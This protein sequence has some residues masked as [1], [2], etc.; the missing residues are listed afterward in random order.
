[1]TRDTVLL[2]GA[3]G[4]VGSSILRRL[5]IDGYRV[6]AVV[7]KTSNAAATKRIAQDVG[8]ADH[9]S[10]AAVPDFGSPDAFDNAVQGVKYIIHTASPVPFK[11]ASEDGGDWEQTLITPAVRG[12]L[13]LLASA[14]KAGSVH[15]VVITSSLAALFPISFLLGQT[16]DPIAA[17]TRQPD[18]DPPYPNHV[19][20]YMASKT[21][22]LNAAEEWMRASMRSFDVIHIHPGYI[23]GRDLSATTSAA[24]ET[25]SNSLILS[26]A[27]GRVAPEL[28]GLHAV[29]TDVEDVARVHVTA[30]EDRVPG[31]RSFVVSSSGHDCA[32]WED[33]PA[34]VAKHYPQ[35]VEAGT[36]PANAAQ[37]ATLPADVRGEETKEVFGIRM[38]AFEDVVQRAIGHYVELLASEERSNRRSRSH[39]SM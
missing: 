21:A 11:L 35:R 29:F 15:R 31:N 13:G 26:A 22:A 18:M 14:A 33:V 34:I 3:T 39:T 5:L 6:H 19:V 36:F 17:D 38:G 2:T 28:P 25:S 1:M 8:K 7:R 23:L 24:Y 12:T 20:A 27:M 16:S 37:L 30:L 4:F 9:L 32:R 10:F